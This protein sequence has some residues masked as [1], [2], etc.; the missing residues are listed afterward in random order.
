M[1]GIPESY[2]PCACVKRDRRG[3]LI[4]IMGHHQSVKRCRKCKA[5]RPEGWLE[6]ID[7]QQLARDA[8]IARLNEAK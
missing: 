4:A 6:E 1:Q 7:K 5:Q 3:N 2:W 8:E